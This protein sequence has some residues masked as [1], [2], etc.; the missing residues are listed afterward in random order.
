MANETNT[1]SRRPRRWLRWLGYSIGGL[2]LILVLAYFVG[3]SGWAL[4]SFIL[5]KVS[6]AMNAKVTVEDAS[7]SPFSAVTLRGLKVETTGTEPLV[8]AKEVRLRYSLMDIIKG[9]V[10]VAEI[11]LESP[12]VNLVTQADGSSNLDPITKQ[13]Q[14]PKPAEPAQP[15]GEAKPV[16]LNLVKFALKNAR[17]RKTD[18]RADGTKQ[19]LELVAVNVTAEDIGNNKVGQLGL[20][21][22]IRLDQGFSGASNGVIGMVVG[23]NFNLQLDA[24][25]QPQTVKGLTKV[26]ITEAK[27]AFAQAAGMGLVLNAD[28][29]PTQ[30]NDVSLRVAQNGNNLAALTVSGPFNAG[31]Q[32][33]KLLVALSG[34]DRRVLNMVGGPLGIDFNQ[35]AIGSTNT[36]ELSQKGRVIT[37]NGAV[38]VANLSLTQQGQTTPALDVRTGY[39]V[40]Y[41]QT[42]QT[43]LVQS[44]TLNGTQ[45]R[46]EFL[47][48]ALA[49]PMLLELGKA[50][51]GVDESA[52]NLVITNFNL[53]DWRAFAGTNAT[54]T[55]GRLDVDLGLVS[56]Q[57]GKK[58][59]LQLTTRLRELSASSG[60]N[61][62]ENADLGFST[63]GT[64]Q[65][66]SAVNLETWRVDFARA[67]QA[68]L[69]A[70]GALQ[71][72]TRS[73]DADVQ[74]TLETILP[75]VAALVSVPGL[76]VSAGSLKFAGR[77]TQKNTTPQLTNN[78]ALDRAVL[79]KLNLDNFTGSLDSNRFDRFVA[80]LDVDILT[81]GDVAEIRKLSGALRQSDQPGG[82]FEV[83]GNFNTVK[84]SGEIN[85]QLLDLNH[86]T[87][88]S[89][90]AAALG[91]KQLE[92][93]TINSKTAAKFGGPTDMAVK[94]EWH[95]A[96]LVVND[97]S[98][99]V[100]RTP[101]AVDFS[102]DVAQVNQV[103]DLKS[104]Q[105]ALRKT[106]RAPNS[107]NVGGRID[108]TKSNAWTGA[109]KVSSDGLDLTPYYDLFAGDKPTSSSDKP[110]AQP[111][112]Q[113]APGPEV[114]P[115]AMQ[116][117]FAQ[118][119]AE[120][121]IAKLF[122][123]E[124]A[125]SNWV[126]KATIQ[127]NRVTVNPFALSLNGGPVSLTAL[128]N[129]GVPGYEYD[130][131]ARLDRVPVE[132][133]VNTFQPDKR[134]QVK[135]DLLTM[136]SIKGAGLTGAG[137]RKN[138]GGSVVMT[139]TNAN[140]QISQNKYVQMLL[141]P[142]AFALQVPEL[143]NSPLNWLD[144]RAGIGGGTVTL[145]NA[146]AESSLFRAG[147][148]S[149]T[150]TLKDV[151]TNSTFNNLP[152][153][154]ELRRSVAG[155]AKNLPGATR[156]TNFVAL[157]YFYSIGGTLG[158]PKPRVDTKAVASLLLQGAL[159]NVGGDA[160]KVLKGLGLGGGPSTNAA[161]TNAASTNAVGNL[162]QGLGA[163][164]DKSAKTNASATNAPAKG[165][166]G[167]FKLNDLLK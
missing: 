160:G 112:I 29:T 88:K 150:M 56:Q 143:A 132:P 20:A 13:A 19:V 66:F 162:I 114:E 139:L 17:I 71:Y 60:A 96:N 38:A 1:N 41:D 39:A 93:V 55:S 148:S 92:S 52:F 157:P 110:A 131:N 104:V 84:K 54:L 152:V 109:V 117:P 31:T 78:P 70:G 8:S 122:L 73:Q 141:Q 43:A 28:L 51:G 101:L 64:L 136:A 106:E 145:T 25:L 67:G 163:L 124:I 129:V 142:L 24:A 116:L 167:G 87:L 5:P 49:R 7:L 68:A 33:G 86:H 57:A 4:K 94:T 30:L 127:D 42:N 113:P 22:N 34:V 100:P 76:N 137:L 36:V 97:P 138:L 69:T 26:D 72:N 85:A 65:D 151:L 119:V 46:V 120:L 91:D 111:P 15:K 89:F 146:I 155:W 32:E 130:F 10:N 90:L 156:S 62:I 6:S 80:A 159:Q 166:S 99:R 140:V 77:I 107:L 128:A 108:M 53:A 118:F 16:Q 35:T 63:R 23:G 83:T 18:H 37:V 81:R 50:S 14:A 74:V 121:S 115:P 48:G 123:R 103:V 47:R 3:T 147:L 12:V 105:L 2:L 27:G 135:G 133:I 98:G 125:I 126:I 161:G 149:G 102:A 153:S 59:A 158:E 9:N 144:A 154:I 75:Q 45:N 95:V 134:G 165:K 11:T 164:L 58:L 82:G 44:F 40:T 21:A 79:G 61:R